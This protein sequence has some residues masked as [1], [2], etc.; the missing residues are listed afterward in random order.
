MKSLYLNEGVKAVV[1]TTHGEGFGL[2]L[3]EAAQNGVPVV[4]P[5]WSGHKDF[6]YAPVQ[7]KKTKKT[8]KRPL[9]TRVDYELNKVQPEAVWEQVII[10]ES[11]WCFPKER[12]YT[13]A[14][15]K[16]YDQ[17][18]NALSQAK[19]LQTHILKT[20]TEEAQYEKFMEALELGSAPD[21]KGPPMQ[22]Y[23]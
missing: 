6:L 5:N 2:P 7:N 19:K 11:M 3:F 16:V 13:N 14:L 10:P 17:Y 18:S 23:K 8:K 20:F 9:F 4:A 15:R 21:E 1:T 12:S 22:V